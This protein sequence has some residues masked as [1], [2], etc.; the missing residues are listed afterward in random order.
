MPNDDK[1][2]AEA[3]GPQIFIS[4]HWHEDIL[5]ARNAHLVKVKTNDKE[6]PEEKA[7]KQE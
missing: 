3:S 6:G 7:I 5:S 4:T 1:T 2:T